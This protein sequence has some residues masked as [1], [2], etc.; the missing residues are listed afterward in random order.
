MSCSITAGGRSRL[1]SRSEQQASKRVAR[2]TTSL[3]TRGNRLRLTRSMSMSYVSDDLLKCRL[4]EKVMSVFRILRF[5]R[6]GCG[7]E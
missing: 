1:V 4:C 2:K 3:C 5:T 6:S 7:D